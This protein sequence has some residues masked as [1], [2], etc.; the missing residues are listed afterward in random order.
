MTNGHWLRSYHAVIAFCGMLVLLISNGMILSGL[1]PFR[2]QLAEQLNASTAQLAV[3]D[4]ITF[5]LLAIFAPLTG[6]LIDR[7][8]TRRLIMVGFA[9]LA[10][11]Y[12]AYG[13]VQ[14][15]W[16]IYLIHVG[17]SVVLAFAGLVPVVALVSRWFAAERGTA[18]GIALVGSSLGSFVFPPLAEK[19][20]IPSYGW[21]SAFQFEAIAALL[22]I[23]L[24]FLLVRSL[25]SDRGMTAYGQGNVEVGPASDGAGL[26]T[27]E[28]LRTRSFWILGCCAALT[29]FAML[30]TLYQLPFFMFSLGI[31]HVSGGFAAMLGAALVGK[32]LFGYLADLLGPKRVFI[33]NLAVMALGAGLLASANADT[34]IIKLAVY[35]VGWGGLYTMLQLLT[36][37]SFGLKASGKILGLI[38]V[39]DCIGG[40]AG[41]L[42]L[43]TLFDRYGSFTPGFWLLCGL[44]LTALF[45]A[46]AI[47]QEF[48]PQSH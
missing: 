40:G 36:V 34:V 32:F 19:W 26:T 5:W 41:S 14:A 46:T 2:P 39:F 13:S 11:C 27:T 24:V 10:V 16:Q 28:A 18:I 38:A 45:A 20:L 33:A 30:G 47:R 3:G 15:L 48:S 1:T 35:G 17:F 22:G 9:L 7:F 42:A 21:R 25:P 43:A 4:T 44:I 31:S 12:F 6:I 29:F 23:G 8:G 37:N